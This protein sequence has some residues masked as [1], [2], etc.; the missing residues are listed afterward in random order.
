MEVTEVCVRIERTINT[1]NYE[2]IKF[3]LEQTAAV[4]AEHGSKEHKLAVKHLV[5]STTDL[6]EKEVNYGTQELVDE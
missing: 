3:S 2:N 6:L 5:E 1:G 4:N